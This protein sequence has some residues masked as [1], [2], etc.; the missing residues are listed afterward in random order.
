MISISTR[1]N[2]AIRAAALAVAGAC[3]F[4]PFTAGAAPQGEFDG[5]VRGRL[6][7]EAKPG[8]SDAA[9][10]KLL[11]PY[12]GKKRKLGQSNLHVIDLPGHASEIA[13]LK[14]LEHRPEFKFAE[15]DRLVESTMAVNDPYIGSAWHINK[16]GAPAAWDSTRGSGITIAIL[17]SGIESTHPDLKANLVAGRN[18]YNNNTDVSDICGHGTAVAGAAAAASNNGIG[19]AGTAGAAKIMPLRIAYWNTTYSSCYAS[20]STIAAGITYAAD[21]GARV[22]NASYARLA[23]SS[24]VLSAARYM[25]SKGGLVFVSAGNAN[26]DEKITADPALIVVSATTSSDARASFSS[27]GAAVSLAAPGSGIWTT[28]R[29][30]TYLS[31]NG[32]SFSSPIAAG[33]AAMMMAARPDLKPD[34]IQ[35]LMYSTAVDL[36][37][38]GRDVYFGHGRVNAAAA[39]AAAKSY[40]VT[41]DTTAPKAAI[42][43]P[44]GN[45]SVSGAVAVNVGASDNVGVA[46]VELKANGTVVAVDSAAPYSFSWN[47]TGVANGMANLVAVAYDAA[48]NSGSSA[49]VAVNVA[50]A[51]TTTTTVDTVKPTIT[52]TNPV[53]GNVSGRVTISISV[54]DNSDVAGIR[55]QLLIDGVLRAYGSGGT[56]A[57]TWNAAKYTAGSH[58]IRVTAKDK[59]GNLAEKTLVVNNVK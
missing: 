8:L 41:S 23:A 34:T 35:S 12:G 59:A 18:I 15:L 11:K 45:A 26:V 3:A 24:A 58:T 27:Y 43:A 44:L 48:G 55:Q 36:G 50:N 5:F 9:F 57:W 2:P 14:Q 40:G 16:I 30:A 1:S 46:R 13:I 39:V 10:D 37:S 29:N 25:K 49:S 47:S 52:I 20:Y 51:T 33:V 6:L 53:A 28:G 19:V 31:K 42:S 21:N 7:V 56:L 32:T 22:A 38:A 4:A 54:T 17:D